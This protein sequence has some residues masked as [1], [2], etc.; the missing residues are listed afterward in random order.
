MTDLLSHYL[1]FQE[2]KLAESSL[3]A[4]DLALV[5]WVRYLQGR[6]PRRELT[7]D[8]FTQANLK[9]FYRHLVDVKGNA[10]LTSKKRVQQVQHAWN[11]LYTKSDAYHRIVPRPVELDMAKPLRRT[12]EAPTWQEMDACIEAA[13]GWHKQL[14]IVLRSTGL[15]VHQAM[16]LRM[17]DLDLEKLLLRL[18]P[19]LGKSDHERSGRTIPVPDHFL[20]EVMGWSRPDDWLVPCNRKQDT[21]EAR[22]RDMGRAWKRSGVREEVWGGAPGHHG[23]P[24]HAFR[25]GYVS[26]LCHL[27]A[28]PDAVEALV[29]HKLPGLRST[30]TTIQALPLRQAVDLVP[31]ISGHPD[32]PPASRPVEPTEPASNVIQFPNRNAS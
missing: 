6:Y 5:T 23:R 9:G 21:R 31:P 8:H 17:D 15:R 29:G 4:V 24:H 20:Q 13:N 7:A 12:V 18:R 11:W 26:G 28:N 32:V 1:D 2:L 30:Y 16:N 14:A 22:S 10:L 3:K 19:E 27:G 25:K